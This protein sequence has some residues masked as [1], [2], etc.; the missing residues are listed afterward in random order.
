MSDARNTQ[1]GA[2]SMNTTKTAIVQIS[3]AVLAYGDDADEALANA[4]QAYPD[5]TAEDILPLGQA[6][7]GDCVCVPITG[8]CI[9][10]GGDDWSVHD[11]VCMTYG[12]QDAL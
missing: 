4:Q 10:A 1:Q 3:T 11:G 6:Q 2:D 8:A 9:E 5:L 12:E 7:A